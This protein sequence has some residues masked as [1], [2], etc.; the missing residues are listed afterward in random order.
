MRVSMDTIAR[1][2]ESQVSSDLMR[3]NHTRNASTLSSESVHVSH[4]EL[5]Q[6][7]HVHF[8]GGKALVTERVEGTVQSNL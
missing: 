6:D 3:T 1:V 5:R 7:A 4:G 2:R 8:A